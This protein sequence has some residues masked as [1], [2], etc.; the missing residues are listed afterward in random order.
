MIEVEYPGSVK[1]IV[2]SVRLN[3]LH[4][5]ANDSPITARLFAK[6]VVARLS[7]AGHVAYFAGGCVRDELLGLH[8][9]DYDVATDATPARIK[10][11]F[12]RTSEVGAAFGVMLVYDDA[13]RAVV[14]V[15]TFRADGPYSD[16]RRPDSVRF[17]D[18]PSDAAR[19]DFTINALFLDPFASPEPGDTTEGRV[20]DFVGGRADLQARVIK[21]VGE[22]D[23]R[24]AE[25]HLRALRAVRF[26]ARLGF[27][28]DQGTADAIQRHAADLR[29]VSR[30][31]IGEEL[32][33]MFT[34]PS[35]AAAAEL[36]ERLGLDAPVL[37]EPSCVSGQRLLAG[38]GEPVRR[39][40]ETAH[41]SASEWLIQRRWPRVPSFST[42]LAAWA[43]DRAMVR[44][45]QADDA[46]E[47]LSRLGA[48]ALNVLA[49][50]FTKRC[51]IALCLSNDD[52]EELSD[53]IRVVS[54]LWHRW[55]DM[56][57]ADQKRAAAR[58]GF[59]AVLS[60]LHAAS[61]D[62]AERILLRYQGLRDDGIGI[63]PTPLVT[64]DTLIQAGHRPGPRFKGLLDSVY[65]AQLEGRI[66]GSAEAMELVRQLSV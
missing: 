43:I 38:I 57:I 32:K 20:I 2:H 6:Q 33:R 60:I 9:T 11:L 51:R 5:P 30:E 39:I 42:A 63:N 29:G 16:A 53:V 59:F 55:M 26:A 65:D 3:S 44:V 45:E 28:I 17:S 46:A 34:H 10:A 31:R 49:D 36:L 27:A 40:A 8:P 1:A 15:A 47:G 54:V 50:E 52:A 18:A 12:E 41:V 62:R 58:P 48:E 24:L 64:G 4:M 19:R 13:S 56:T 14:E 7:G 23:Q 66:R 22:P 61:C 35:R 37:N 25:D 21:A